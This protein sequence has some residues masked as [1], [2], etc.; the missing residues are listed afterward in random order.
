MLF[1]SR[2]GMTHRMDKES[3]QQNSKKETEGNRKNQAQEKKRKT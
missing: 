2:I 3:L 1:L